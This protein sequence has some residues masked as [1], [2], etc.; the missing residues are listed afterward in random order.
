MNLRV[1]GYCAASASIVVVVVVIFSYI[2]L[3]FNAPKK[4]CLTYVN[5][6]RCVCMCFALT[7]GKLRH[8]MINKVQ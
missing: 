7:L 8:K 6:Y 3:V 5:I 1:C 2:C 4:D